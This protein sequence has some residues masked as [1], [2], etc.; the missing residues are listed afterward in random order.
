LGFFNQHK[1]P[2]KHYRGLLFLF[3]PFQKSKINLQ[4]NC[5]LWKRVYMEQK[6][7]IEKMWKNDIYN[8]NPFNNFNIEWDNLELEVKEYT[9]NHQ[10]NGWEIIFLNEILIMQVIHIYIYIY[11]SLIPKKLNHIMYQMKI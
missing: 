8:F 3:K 5:D 9:K 1:Y 10:K 2:I 4:N 6:N 7:D 11:I